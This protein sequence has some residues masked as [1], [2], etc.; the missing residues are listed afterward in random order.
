MFDKKQRIFRVHG[1]DRAHQE[2]IRV[3]L[4]EKLDAWCASRKRGDGFSVREWL[5]GA[6]RNW[7]GTPMQE[8]YNYYRRKN[9]GDV[10]AYR[11]AGK[12]AGRIL[13]AVIDSDEGHRFHIT[14]EFRSVR[15]IWV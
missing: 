8:L 14:R 7:N 1:V 13:K 5:G 2:E 3:Y 9:R 10:Y 6:E 12:A 11:E 15:Y 4:R